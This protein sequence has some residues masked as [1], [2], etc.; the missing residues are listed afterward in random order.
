LWDLDLRIRESESERET[1]EERFANEPAARR[2]FIGFCTSFELEAIMERI[3]SLLFGGSHTGKDEEEERREHAKMDD[4]AKDGDV[5]DG[6]GDDGDKDTTLRAN[7]GPPPANAKGGN[8]TS[9]TPNE[10][11]PPANGKGGNSTSTTPRPRNCRMCKVPLKGH[12][13]PLKSS[14]ATAPKIKLSPKKRKMADD[15]TSKPKKPRIASEG[16]QSSTKKKSESNPQEHYEGKSLPDAPSPEKGDSPSS[17]HSGLLLLQGA[18]MSVM[19]EQTKV[20]NGPKRLTSKRR[21]MLCRKCGVPLKGHNC[22]HKNASNNTE[23]TGAKKKGRKQNLDSE[24]SAPDAGRKLSH[25]L[26]EDTSYS[27]LHNKG[28]DEEE[29]SWAADDDD[30]TNIRAIWS[31]KGSK[32]TKRSA[33]SALGTSTSEDDNDEKEEAKQQSSGKLRHYKCTMCGLPLKGHV[34]QYRKAPRAAELPPQD[35]LTALSSV[36]A[37]VASGSG[38]VDASSLALRGSNREAWTEVMAPAHILQD[39]VHSYLLQFAEQQQQN[40]AGSHSTSITEAEKVFLQTWAGN[41]H[42]ELFIQNQLTLENIELSDAR[43]NVAK[44]V[45][46]ERDALVALRAKIRRVQSENQQLED[47]IATQ[48]QENGTNAA[49][50]RFLDAIDMLRRTDSRGDT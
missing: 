3:R 18:A 9:T 50:S 6:A 12:C 27:L 47:R 7:A 22:P 32:P 21:V 19:E 28:D 39:E 49:A 31:K 40:K 30:A 48:R 5:D 43:R 44:S 1:G 16:K 17:I 25:F 36:A 13:C 38:R 8:S 20:S 24:S 4:F 34:C 26:D 23:T 45:S 15:K 46:Q 2:E 33:Q 37:A 11:P 14:S 35:R 41:V 42:N 10:G 29:S